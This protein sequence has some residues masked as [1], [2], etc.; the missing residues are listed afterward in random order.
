MSIS[1]GQQLAFNDFSRGYAIAI[2]SIWGLGIDI[3]RLLIRYGR[4]YPLV[5]NIHSMLML[6][7]G[8]LTVMYVGG[9]IVV[10]QNNYGAG[11]SGLTG[12]ALAQFATSIVLACLV[13][14]QFVLGFLVRVEMFGR[15]LSSA[16]FTVK[17]IHRIGGWV[18]TVFGKVVATL[19]VYTNCSEVV[20][21]GWLFCLGGLAILMLVFEVVYR[22]QSRTIILSSLFKHKNKHHRYHNEIYQALL[23]RKEKFNTYQARGVRYIIVDNCMYYIDEDFMHPGGEHIFTLLNGQEVNYYLK[24]AKAIAPDLPRHTHTK[25]VAKYLE[26]RLVGELNAEPLLINLKLANDQVDWRITSCLRTNYVGAYLV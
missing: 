23:E 1:L 5:I 2:F 6:L 22:S 24:G 20:F 25:F 3:P 19:V 14:I 10:Y 9:E 21:K 4:A 7:L 17:R 11:Y 8:L 13:L 18:V 15:R 12:A 16:L 26:N